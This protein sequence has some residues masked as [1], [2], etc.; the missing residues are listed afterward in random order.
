MAERSTFDDLP[1][2]R[3]PWIAIPLALVVIALIGRIDYAT[4]SETSIIVLYLLP[5]ALV[6]WVAG[7]VWA[8]VAA[9]VS[10]VLSLFGDMLVID[11]FRNPLVPYWNAAVQFSVFAL[12]GLALAALRSSVQREHVASRIDYVTG[13]AN[14]R[15]F[16]EAADAE[17]ARVRRFGRSLTLVYLD[18]DDFKHIN[19]TKGHAEGDNVLRL[20]ADALRDTTRE[21][22]TVA[23]LGGDEFVVLLPETGPEAAE[24]AVDRMKTS[25]RERVT[26]GSTSITVSMG[27]ATFREP[28]ES[29]DVMLRAADRLLYDAKGAGGDRSVHAT[30]GVCA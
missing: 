13:L 16:A 25:L 9:L 17:L 11:S 10:A 4:G 21:V 5:I 18:C 12:F 30:F 27:T 26:E 19:D 1:L 24:R 7:P 29:L 3:S 23:R 14:W 28:P 2:P 8:T 15:A 6:A 22:D 20:V